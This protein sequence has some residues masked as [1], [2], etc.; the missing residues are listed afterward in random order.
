MSSVVATWILGASMPFTPEFKAKAELILR[1]RGA[2]LPCSRCGHAHFSILDGFFAPLLQQEP[3]GI[4]LGS[5]SVPMI[6]VAC[7]KCGNTWTHSVGVL[8][9]MGDL[10]AGGNQ[11]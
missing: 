10:K 9:L 3:A 4:V 6:A 2:N 1:G 8:G 7:V 11:Q 5:P